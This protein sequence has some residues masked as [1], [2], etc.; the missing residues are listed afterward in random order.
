MNAGHDAAALDLNLLIVFD[1]LLR[2]RSVT[3]AAGTLGVTQSAISHSLKRLRDFF[4]DPLFIK[5]SAGMTPTAKALALRP[6]ILDLIDTLRRHILS[7]AEFE[8]L[9]AK[10]TFTLCMSDMGELAFVPSLF[11]QLKVLA[12]HCD[13][14]TIQ[15]TNDTLEATMGAGK[16]DLAIGSVRNAP[17][18]LYQQELYSHTFVCIVS[19]KNDEVGAEI[20]REKFCQ[21][22]HIAVTLPGQASTP[23][24]SALEDAGIKR[25]IVISTPHFL[26]VPLMLDQHPEFIATVP[27]ALG[28]VFSRHRL[29]RMLEPPVVLPTFNM[30]QYWHP[31][32]H[33][34][35][36]NIW[37]RNVV[38]TTFDQLPVSMR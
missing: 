1:A 28:T 34:D 10:R 26:I 24:D 20:S 19:V 32:F 35:R 13:L 23:Y 8:P 18:D 17:N 15:V 7:Q 36:A 22:P 30:R 2:E 25:R 29:V 5:T 9:L 37:L 16:A 12:P 14:H 38:K 6:A 33:H 21:M 3:E 27:R 31:R 4:A 11:A